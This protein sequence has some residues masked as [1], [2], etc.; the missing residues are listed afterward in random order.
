MEIPTINTKFLKP[1]FGHNAML[2][3]V[4][5][6]WILFKHQNYVNLIKIRKYFGGKD[7][8]YEV[9]TSTVQL[10]SRVCLYSNAID[11]EFLIS[12]GILK[13][14]ETKRKHPMNDRSF[15]IKMKQ[16]SSF[17]ARN[18]SLAITS[19]VRQCHNRRDFLIHLGVTSRSS[20]A[21]SVW[22]P[23]PATPRLSISPPAAPLQHHQS[24][25][26]TATA[27]NDIDFT[28]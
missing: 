26:A 27:H 22:H 9:L 23:I 4:N 8:D 25:V 28:A 11:K 7:V 13:K 21:P 2:K 19:R 12:W 5:E 10:Q 20:R 14:R 16:V 15:K 3:K 6:I 24:L 1:H 17:T 18:I